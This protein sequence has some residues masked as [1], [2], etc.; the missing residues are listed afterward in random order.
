MKKN[1]LYLK[2]TKWK[3]RMSLN[4]D[5]KI[6][7]TNIDILRLTED[8]IYGR[9]R[10][11]FPKI[12]L[13]KVV[14]PKVFN[15]ILRKKKDNHPRDHIFQVLVKLEENLFLSR[16]LL[17]NTITD[18]K[19]ERIAEKKDINIDAEA[20]KV[21]ND[22]VSALAT[23]SDKIGNLKFITK[24][25]GDKTD[26]KTIELYE[27]IITKLTKLMILEKASSTKYKEKKSLKEHLVFTEDEDVIFALLFNSV[28]TDDSFRIAVSGG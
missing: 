12:Y 20:Q 18:D 7:S 8:E 26:S 17:V 24:S 27:S 25:S 1:N 11:S 2:L 4:I 6:L 23:Y 28:K 22:T 19:G 5:Y 14:E 21:L 3:N 9:I 15:E 10:V 16:I 13:N